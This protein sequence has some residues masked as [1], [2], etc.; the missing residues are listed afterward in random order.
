[1]KIGKSPFLIN[2]RNF[3][4]FS[5]NLNLLSKPAHFAVFLP[6]LGGPEAFPFDSPAPKWHILKIAVSL[7]LSST[8][9]CSP[10]T[11]HL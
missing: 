9:Y 10:L 7:F 1:M 11:A 2:L 3:L 6:K 8:A 4:A 5:R